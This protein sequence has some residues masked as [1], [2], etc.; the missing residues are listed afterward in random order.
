MR[1]VSNFLAGK[2]N[3]A[4]IDVGHVHVYVRR[5]L[6]MIEAEAT[7]TFDVANVEV[8]EDLRGRGMFTTFIVNLEVLLRS[9]LLLSR[10]NIQVLYVEN[11]LNHRLAVSLAEWDFTRIEG[12]E[13][14]C[15]YRR[16]I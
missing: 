10:S 15:F 1:A 5:G 7:D 16:L 8:Q 14:P 3:N 11:V 12:S 13:P 6:H 9:E 4:W 2:A